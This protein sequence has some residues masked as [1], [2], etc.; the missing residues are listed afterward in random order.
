MHCVY[1]YQEQLMS[2]MIND[3]NF[4]QFQVTVN[5]AAKKVETQA[6]VTKIRIKISTT[7]K[8]AFYKPVQLKLSIHACFEL[9]KIN[10]NNNN[11]LHTFVDVNKS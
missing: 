4:S 10:N 7:D 2:D 5:E 3:S 11:I 1:T 9:G 6:S 8:K